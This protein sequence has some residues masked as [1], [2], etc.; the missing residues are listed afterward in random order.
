MSAPKSES[1]AL[2]T[3]E[4]VAALLQCSRRHV[5]G[6]VRAGRVPHILL[7]GSGERNVV[8]FEADRLRQWIV[9]HRKGGG[10]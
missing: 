10:A 4:D 1:Q 8:R 7:P 6:L 9:S 2:L 5:Y 3:V